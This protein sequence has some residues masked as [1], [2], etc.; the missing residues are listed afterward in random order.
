MVFGLRPRVS[1]AASCMKQARNDL[2]NLLAVEVEDLIVL[3]S[4]G[5]MTGLG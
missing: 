4:V 5:A 3:R 1:I 2:K